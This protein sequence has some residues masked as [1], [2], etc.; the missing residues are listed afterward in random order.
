MSAP[1]ATVQ[2]LLPAP[3]LS[4]IVSTGILR[5]TSSSTSWLFQQLFHALH[6]VSIAGVPP[7]HSL[8]QTAFNTAIFG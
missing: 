5:T 6:G 8:V 1:C 3:V 4:I 2:V 7:M